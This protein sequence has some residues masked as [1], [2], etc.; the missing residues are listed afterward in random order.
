MRPPSDFGAF[1]RWL[2]KVTER[3]W[4]DYDVP[5]RVLDRYDLLV[6]IDLGTDPSDD[7]TEPGVFAHMSTE[8]V[9]FRR[10]E[11]G[12]PVP[13]A[14]VPSLVFSEVMRDVGLFVEVSERSAPPS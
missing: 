9:W 13:I 6:E 2:R 10:P 4:D 5:R 12:D 1:L 11:S 7:L 8:R 14:E 3:A